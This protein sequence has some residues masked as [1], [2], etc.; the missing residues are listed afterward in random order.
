MYGYCQNIHSLVNFVGDDLIIN[1]NQVSEITI[2]KDLNGK[3]SVKTKITVLFDEQNRPF[4]FSNY[5]QENKLIR[6]ITQKYNSNYRKPNYKKIENWSKNQSY[7]FEEEYY[8]Y[9]LDENL[10][11]ITIQ[12]SKGK[13]ISDSSII[14]DS[15][16]NP[17]S[18][19]MKG[20][21][22]YDL[23]I[24]TAVYDY[25]NNEMVIKS[26]NKDGKELSTSKR[27]IGLSYFS[28]DK[29]ELDDFGN[30]LKSPD[31]QFEYKY[32][33]LGNWTKKTTFILKDG[34]RFKIS[35][36]SRKIKYKK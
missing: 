29:L 30:I 36:V 16:G 21:N 8:E 28:S 26:F 23:G 15:I 17:I 31:Y 32:D 22:S 25:S 13:L 20:S 24:E 4:K 1:N 14:N 34:K 27:L 18:L 2:N 35:E 11:K 10:I 19:K 5:N 33:K 7:Y 9:D 3:G 12:D 6:R